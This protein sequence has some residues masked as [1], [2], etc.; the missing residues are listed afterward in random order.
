M[1]NELRHA[2]RSL[3]RTPGFALVSILTLALGIGGT[4]AIF[5]VVNRTVLN[6]LPFPDAER[7]VVVWGSKPH[8]G[9]PEIHFS[10][11]DFEDYRRQAHVFDAL[12]AWAEGRVNLTGAAA[13]E[14]VQYAV[15]TSNVLAILGATP[16]LGR[17]FTASQES[18]GTEA[19]AL[20]SHSLWRRQFGEAPD[21]TSR[22]ML[23]DGRTVRIAGVLPRAFAFLTFPDRTDVWLPLG[24]D[25]SQ[26]RRF[27]RGMRSMG[28][29]GK[30]KEGVTIDQ[31]RAEADTVAAG[32]AAQYPRFNTGRR[33]AVTF[34][35]DQVVRGVR[36]GGMMLSV[37]AGGVLAIACANIVGLLLARAT[38]RRR[39]FSIRRALGA[40]RARIVRHQFAESLVLGAAGGSAGL[41]LAV[42]LVDLLVRVPYRS[43][44]LLVPYSVPRDLIGVDG[45]VLLFTIGVTIVIVAAFSLVSGLAH[46][47]TRSDEALRAGAR[48]TG[49]PRQ[50]RARSALVIAEVALTL[51]LLGG[52]GLT[53]RSVQSLYRVDPG[54][55]PATVL[56]MDVVLSPSKY[57]NPER[58]AAYYQEAIDRLAALPQTIEAGAVEFLPMSGLDG[59]TGFYVEGRP[60]PA[61]ADEQQTHYRSISDTYFDVMGIAMASGRAFT[62]RDGAGAQRVAIVN[63]A[64]ARRYWPGENP[65]GKRVALDLEAMRFFP[66]R[67]PT[68]DIP[69]AMREIVGIVKDIRHSSLES[70]P[71]PELYIPYLQ[72]PA[73]D[74]TLVVRSSA[75]PAILAASARD[76]VGTID[77][78]QPIRRV[79]TLSGLMTGTTAQPRANLILLSAFAFIALL[80]AVVGIYGLL[81]YVVVQ[82]KRELGIRVALGAQ[83]GQIHWMILRQGLVLVAAGFALGIPASLALG[84]LLRGLL[85]GIE[86]VDPIT[87]T[88]AAATMLI[89]STAAIYLPAKRATEVNPVDTLRAE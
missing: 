65:I 56:A 72:R 69:A 57:R 55:S 75:D 15:V 20:I 46:S 25:P 82:R 4:S 54:F 26:G 62:P 31:V 33:F 13:P 8:E 38:T 16:I 6:P 50:H 51:V 40:S 1:V 23:L 68:L 5:T 43:D 37:A 44:S 12:G 78:D 88:A 22:S 39:E 76:A 53:V 18:P 17:T 10:Q 80:L 19:V 84:R 32:L 49:E 28:V 89:V 30:L 41:L 71:V 3:L 35:H 60:E 67:P 58:I 83:P 2:S 79:E 9:L 11:P 14:Q 73:Q 74:M 77:A 81:A 24:A 70:S 47:R 21:V 87:M 66:D 64:M 63:E 7:L 36:T 45:V 29:L 34:L 85:F 86:G 61:R 42:W 48:S 52:A 27:A 59:S